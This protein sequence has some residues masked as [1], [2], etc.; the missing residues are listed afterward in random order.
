[1]MYNS[2][3]PYHSDN[4]SISCTKKNLLLALTLK[5]GLKVDADNISLKIYDIYFLTSTYHEHLFSELSSFMN[6]AP[7]YII[8]LW[9]ER[10]Y[11]T[12]LCSIVPISIHSK[13]IHFHDTRLSHAHLLTHFIKIQYICFFL[14]LPGV[15]QVTLGLTIVIYP[16][17]KRIYIYTTRYIQMTQVLFLL[18]IY[19]LPTMLLLYLA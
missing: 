19:N 18:K 1:M 16:T 4:K 8:F 11:L 6:N 5:I 3:F 15:H 14:L 7:V 17:V 12:L 10:Y 2:S 13:F 9:S